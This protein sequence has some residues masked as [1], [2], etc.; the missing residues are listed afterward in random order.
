MENKF[1]KYVLPYIP[2]AG[3][4]GM[5]CKKAVGKNEAIFFTALV[6]QMVSIGFITLEIMQHFCGC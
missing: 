5:F 1:F 6:W 3:A 4:I 2:V